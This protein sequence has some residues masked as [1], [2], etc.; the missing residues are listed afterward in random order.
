MLCDDCIHNEVCGEEGNH[1]PALVTCAEFKSGM[2]LKWV[3]DSTGKYIC[4]NCNHVEFKPK[5]FCADCGRPF[6]W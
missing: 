5:R 2:L 3:K 1:D 6:F 4:P